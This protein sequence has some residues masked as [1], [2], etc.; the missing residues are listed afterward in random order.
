KPDELRVYIEEA[1]GISRYKERRKDTEARMR[2]TRENLER[3]TDIR[4]ELERQLERLKR[5]AAA[6]EKYRELKTQ[7]RQ[8]WGELRAVQ[9]RS[10]NADVSQQAGRI[11]EL[12]L[13]QEA[14]ITR[15]GS[16]DAGIE[17]Q[18]VALT[19]LSDQHSRV[20]ADYY[21]LGE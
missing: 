3:L 19:D 15:Q 16:L 8:L 10:L 4:D 1:A 20:Q 14:V 12:E 17:K 18:R 21:S 7:E 6:A 2:R 11:G 5:Q 13:A 9:W